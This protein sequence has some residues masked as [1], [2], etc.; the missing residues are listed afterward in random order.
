[1]DKI[2]LFKKAV[3]TIVGIGT[4]KIIKGIIENNV[5][6]TTAVEKT[7]VT[8]ASVAIGYA[9]S[10]E[11]S[12]YTDRKIDEAVALWKK[13]ITNRNKPELKVVN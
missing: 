3:T 6:T 12:E 5:D 13:H 1:M 4:T 2:A 8:A 10:E 11:T 7:T 9:I